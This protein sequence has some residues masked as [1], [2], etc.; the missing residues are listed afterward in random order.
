MTSI[1][2]FSNFCEHSKKLVQNLAK[3]QTRK[4]VHYICIDKRVVEGDKVFVILESG[5]KIVLPN[6]VTKVPALL[7]LNENF[8]VL[9]GDQIYSF[10]APEQAIKTQQATQG[11][12][13]PLAFSL[14]GSGGV[15]LITSDQY[16]FLDMDAAQLNTQ[17]DGGMRQMHSYTPL[18]HVDK[19]APIDPTTTTSAASRGGGVES[20]T[21]EQLQR[22]RENDLKR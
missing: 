22:Q 19:F 2:Y 15:G 7:L 20:M 14:G 4:D 16:S 3:T 1:L 17:G 8:K 6:T 12:M 21:I 18:N 10:F 11:H 5:Q 9:T 13:E